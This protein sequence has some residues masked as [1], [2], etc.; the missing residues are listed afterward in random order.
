MNRDGTYRK[1]KFVQNSKIF[2]CPI[3][4][5]EM[6]VHQFKDMVCSQGHNF[7][8]AKKGYIN[9]LLKAVKT[10]YDK[11]M[12]YSRNLIH[13]SGFFDP[14]LESLSNSIIKRIQEKD[15]RKVNILDAGCGDGSHIGQI[16]NK[17]YEKLDRDISGFGVDISKEGILL[18]SKQ[19]FEILWCVADLT[20]LPFASKG[21]DVILNILSPAN[22]DEF[23]RVLEDDGI[24]IKV[25][26][27]KD[28][29]KELRNIF[30]E[31][32]EKQ[33]YSNDEVVKLFSRK[34][35]VLD[36]IE[37]KYSHKMDKDNLAHLIAMTPLSWKATDDKIKEAVGMDIDSISVDFLIIIGEKG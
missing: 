23:Y 20:N 2:R 27:G 25:V 34:F 19:Y 12:F 29:L 17:I 16:I 36:T 14:L 3:C 37:L 10:D 13:S 6:N 15:V 31:G 9:F 30:Y 21:F 11:D 4:K 28:Y 24:L 18:A 8:I 35:R 32:T 1:T 7:N 26:P 22:Y 33:E 5:E